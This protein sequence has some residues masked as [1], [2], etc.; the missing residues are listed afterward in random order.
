MEVDQNTKIT[1][2]GTDRQTGRADLLRDPFLP[3]RWSRTRARASS[4]R[5]S[6]C[7]ARSASR[8]S[9]KGQQTMKKIIDKTRK[10]LK[11]KASIRKRI[12]GTP[13]RPR[14]TVYK[15]NRHTYVQAID[16]AA[17]SHDRRRLEPG[18]GPARD[19]EQDGGPGEAGAAHRRAAEGEEHHGGR[20]R[21][22]RL[23][24]P[25]QGEGDRRRRPQGRYQPLEGET[26]GDTA[27]EE[28][29]SGNG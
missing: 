28:I 18:E 5:T 17:G 25:R 24:L 20:L 19:R 29:A 12:H 9:S 21:Q 10:R 6:T 14:M 26:R 23:P 3:R 4:T 22:E 27:L 11:R 8:G 16:D 1:V 7:A 2:K 15:S 13:E